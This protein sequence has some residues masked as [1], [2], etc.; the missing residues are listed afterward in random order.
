MN[1]YCNEEL[2]KINVDL[3]LTIFLLVLFYI[4]LCFKIYQIE[5][6]E[7]EIPPSY[8]SVIINSLV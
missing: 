5:D 8:S 7:E 2:F 3:F 6:Q 1:E 4:I